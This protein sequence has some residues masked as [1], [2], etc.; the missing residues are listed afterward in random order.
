MKTPRKL[1]DAFLLL[2]R[3]GLWGEKESF[4]AYFPLTLTEWET[5]YG[6]S[7][8]HAIHGLVYDGM[9]LLPTECYPPKSVLIPWMA[10][11]DQ[12]ERVTQK[13]MHVVCALKQLF[14]QE[15][16]IPFELIKGHSIGQYFPNPLHRFS[17]DIDL[18]FGS[19]EQQELAN[20]RLESVG[21]SVLR[22]KGDSCY[23]IHQ[24]GIEH[25]A[26]LIELHNPILLRKIRQWEKDIF[27]KGKSENKFS[28]HGVSIDVPIPIANHI[29]LSTHILK[30]L[31]NEGIG[32]RQLCDVAIILKALHNETDQKEIEKRCHQLGI[33][34]WMQVLYALLVKYLGLPKEYLPFPSNE[35]PD[36]LLE[37]IWESGDF[38]IYDE[39][40]EK[41]PEGKWSKKW[42]TCKQMSRKAKLFCRYAPSET[43]WWP[44]TLT[45]AR[46]KELF[47][48]HERAN[49]KNTL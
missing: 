49:S 18:Y 9:L 45:A 48:I 44:V 38:G 20:K 10:H 2:L 13:Q 21:I 34:R 42:F 41:R 17:S 14:D 23:S 12:W 24:V 4:D 43:F 27:M 19:P 15:P 30:H 5:I 47:T 7:R 11:V 28:F 46:L 35:N 29:L 1:R 16:K 40:K 37:E 36:T 33:Y 39:R 25:H 31:L 8:K 26:E 3:Q 6:W 32:L 22:G